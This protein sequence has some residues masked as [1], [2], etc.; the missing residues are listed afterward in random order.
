MRTI[1]DVSQHLQ[2][3]DDIVTLHLLLA[4]TGGIIVNQH[5]SEKSDIEFVN[6]LNITSK[7]RNNIENQN[8][9]FE[10]DQN[11]SKIK[12]DIQRK[13]NQRN[14]ELQS[15]LRAEMSEAQ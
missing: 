15:M 13:K 6:S 4:I 2:I 14:K 12:N 10:V 3:L 11:S 7:L 5:E 8:R 1:P 9:A